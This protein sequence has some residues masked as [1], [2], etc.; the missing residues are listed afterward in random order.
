MKLYYETVSKSLLECL[1]KLMSNNVFNDFV[2]VGGTALSLQLGHRVSVDIDLFTSTQYG[3]MNLEEIKS[4]LTTTFPYT[5]CLDSLNKRNLGYMVYIGNC[6]KERIKLDLFYTDEFI[7]P[8]VQYDGLRM[9]SLKDIS[10]MKM[11]AITNN[12]RKKDFWDIHELL[13]YFTLEQMILFGLQR[14]PYALKIDD[15]INSIFNAYNLLQDSE[16]KCLKGKYWELIIEDL[17]TV[18]KDYKKSFNS[19]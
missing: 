2:L 17:Q 15:I 11:Q 16:I 6:Q 7:A 5:D 4:A 9:A 19:K 1:Q 10:A 8:I 13:E 12:K 14:D 3:S 18:A